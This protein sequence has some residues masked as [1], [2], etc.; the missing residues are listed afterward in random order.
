[1]SK[2]IAQLIDRPEAMVASTIAKLEAKTGYQSHDVRLLAANSQKLRSKI[3]ELGFD[4]D[5]TTGEE[6]YHGLL[7]KYGKDCQVVDRA[8]SITAQNGIADRV[9][10]AIALVGKLGQEANTWA[11]KKSAI[12]SI[13]SDFPA[14]KTMRVLRYRSYDSMVKREDAQKLLATANMLES[15]TW[16]KNVAAKIAKLTS[17]SYE[18][19]QVKIVTLEIDAAIQPIMADLHTGLVAINSRALAKTTPVLTIALLLHDSIAKLCKNFDKKQFTTINPV[20]K[21]WEDAE[22]LLAWN[23]GSPVSLNYR[24][25]ANAHLNGYGF[26]ERS[27]EHGVKSFWAKLLESY[28]ESIEEVPSEIANFGEVLEAGAKNTFLSPI[29][30]MAY[31]MEEVES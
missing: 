12:K 9:N 18:P 5:D 25:V 21:W 3:I 22:H 26:N 8:L 16:H 11:L 28:K 1:M 7:A 23:D 14:K 4:P 15:P 6:L 19:K 20:L 24:D 29:N 30:E 13:L 10:K 2:V 31:E 27:K 17:A